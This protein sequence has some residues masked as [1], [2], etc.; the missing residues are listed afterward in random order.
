MKDRNGQPTYVRHGTGGLTIAGIAERR[1]FTDW[2][3]CASPGSLKI[4]LTVRAQDEKKDAPGACT[5]C[6]SVDDIRGKGRLVNFSPPKIETKQRRFTNFIHEP[7]FGVLENRGCLACHNLAKGRPYLQ[8][9]D[10]GNPKNFVS[11]F[12]AVK[13]ELCQTCHTGSMARQDCLL[14]HKYHVD[15]VS[16]PI[17]STK[18]PIE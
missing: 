10:H 15:G 5:K 16:T 13:K 8:S 3:D 14:C 6:H 11:N 12:S 17:M 7:H 9:Y 1:R 2:G 4:E 18:I